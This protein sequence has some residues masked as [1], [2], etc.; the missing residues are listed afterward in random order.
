[1]KIVGGFIFLLA[2]ALWCL[3]WPVIKERQPARYKI[4]LLLPVL[5]LFMVLS[6]LMYGLVGGWSQ[7]QSYLSFLQTEKIKAEFG[8]VDKVIEKLA[9]HLQQKPDAQG[10][11]LLGKLYLNQRQYAQAAASFE[12]AIQWG[13]T[14]KSVKRLQAQALA[15]AQQT[16]RLSLLPGVTVTVVL[17][18]AIRRQFSDDTVVFIVLKAPGIKM[19]IAAVKKQVRDLPLTIRITD[20]SLMIPDA[21]ITD[22]HKL[23]VLAK[24]ALSGTIVSGPGDYQGVRW[25]TNWQKYTQSITVSIT[26]P[27]H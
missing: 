18:P 1:M 15:L 17:P 2:L 26:H 27:I 14:D 11:F 25:V 21:H 19:P 10:W 7:Y 13:A 4:K 22:F 23:T 8:S 3:M 12:K 6:V 16:Q 24:T 9:H 5:T 20:S